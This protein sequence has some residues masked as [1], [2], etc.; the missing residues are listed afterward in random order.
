MTDIKQAT[1]ANDEPPIAPRDGIWCDAECP[2]FDFHDAGPL[3][4]QTE[5]ELCL[6]N[7]TGICPVQAKRMAAWGAEALEDCRGRAD[8]D[9][10]ARHLL[11]T[12]PGADK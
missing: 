10:D 8:R 11:D 3:P 7:D 6:N 4:D 5:E 9:A 2:Q 12:Y 1:G